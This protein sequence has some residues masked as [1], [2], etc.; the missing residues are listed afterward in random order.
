MHCTLDG[1]RKHPFY[2]LDLC[3]G[4]SVGDTTQDSSSTIPQ[5]IYITNTYYPSVRNYPGRLS[6]NHDEACA[7]Q[8]AIWHFRN[9]LEATNHT[10]N[11]N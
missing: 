7:V 3:T 11:R 10:G 1:V 5:A 6:G 9:E 8:F 4:I 2:C